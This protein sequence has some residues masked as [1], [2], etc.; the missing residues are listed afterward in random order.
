MTVRRTR[1]LRPSAAALD[2]SPA[3]GSGR[4]QEF[5]QSELRCPVEVVYTRARKKPLQVRPSR[6][7]PRTRGLE[8][9]MHAFFDSA[10]P[11]VHRAVASWIKSGRRAPRACELL[12]RWILESLEKLPAPVVR[13]ATLRPRGRCHDLELLAADLLRNELAGDFASPADLPHLTWGRQGQSRTRHSIRLGSY[14][15]EGS[16][17]RLHASLD[18]PAVPSW[19]VR[20]VLFHELLHA[21]HPPRKGAGARWIH[22][23]REFRRREHAYPDYARALAWEE[24][25]IKEVIRSARSGKPMRATLPLAPVLAPQPATPPSEPAPAK[26]RERKLSTAGKIQR[27]LQGWLFPA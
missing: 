10:P 15:Q 3:A 25:H 27:V 21:I 4:W 24:A 18:Q 2:A 12:D 19:F 11:E 20:Y 26:T 13:D 8:V 22:H 23:G 7:P 9:R 1:A 16:V 17:V 5:L 14:D 6:T